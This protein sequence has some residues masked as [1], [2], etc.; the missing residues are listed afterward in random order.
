MYIFKND[1]NLILGPFSRMVN[2]NA[3]RKAFIDSS[4]ALLREWGFDGLDLDWEYP[5]S[6]DS[7]KNHPG[8]KQKF[9]QLCSELMA[10]FKR[11]AAERQLPRLMLTAAV[12]AGKTTIDAG[13]EIAKIGKILDVLNLMAYDLHGT[14][15]GMTGHHTAMASDGGR[16]T[17]LFRLKVFRILL[18]TSVTVNSG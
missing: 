12:A 14:W 1:F 5:A 16:S 18:I 10:A 13:Y 3:N 17:L 7:G 2:S 8:D 9:T 6:R 4:I 15:D 11:D